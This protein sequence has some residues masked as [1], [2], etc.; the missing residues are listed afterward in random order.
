MAGHAGGR[1]A[2]RAHRPRMGIPLRYPSAIKGVKG[3]EPPASFHLPIL[4]RDAFLITT[5]LNVQKIKRY[6]EI[7]NTG[8]YT[9]RTHSRVFGPGKSPGYF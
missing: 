3:A 5:E 9:R 2:S 7:R 6:P 4:L 8:H 1:E